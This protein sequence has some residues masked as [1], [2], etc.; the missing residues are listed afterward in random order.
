LFEFASES[1]SLAKLDSKVSNTIRQSQIISTI[2][3]IVRELVD[4]SIDAEAKSIQ[5]SLV[6]SIYYNY[7]YRI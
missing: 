4:N 2:S 5:V 6:S 3:D 7:K 1:M